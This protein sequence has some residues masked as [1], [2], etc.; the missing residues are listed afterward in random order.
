[1][2]VRYIFLIFFR[3][4]LDQSKQPKDELMLHLKEFSICELMNLQVI[5]ET[6]VVILKVYL[7][8]YY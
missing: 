4:Y 3:S 5:G 2:L 7:V 8:I 1:M 6:Y